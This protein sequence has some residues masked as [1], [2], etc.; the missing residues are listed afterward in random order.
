[1]N[2]IIRKMY[3]RAF[4]KIIFSI[5]ITTLVIYIISKE[6]V[7]TFTIIIIGTLWATI[8][9]I[10]CTNGIKVLTSGT[11]YLKEYIKNSNYTINELNDEF[12]KSTKYGT[13]YI[14]NKHAFTISSNGIH[15][16]LIEDIENI[17]Y[18]HLGEN[19]A[20]GRKGYYYLYIKGKN[21]ED[22]IKIYFA[23]KNNLTKSINYL[24]DK[25][26]KIEIKK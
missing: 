8:S 24:I 15:T 12:E 4:L 21:I 18:E 14:G 7:N 25:N 22:N 16:F 20:K 9:L 10:Y 19:L 3:F 1:M 13:I 11:K 23:S 17:S 2:K 5:L 26:K 6:N